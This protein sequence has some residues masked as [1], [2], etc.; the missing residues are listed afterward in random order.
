MRRM[1]ALTAATLIGLG[2][3]TLSPALAQ[4]SG[5]QGGGGQGSSGEG[6]GPAR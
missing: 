6:S 1:I 3:A 5:G 2:G 4:G